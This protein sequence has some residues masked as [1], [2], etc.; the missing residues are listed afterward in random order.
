MNHLKFLDDTLI[1]EDY[2]ALQKRILPIL[3]SKRMGL[4]I[5]TIKTK[6]VPNNLKCIIYTDDKIIEY[7]KDYTCVR[8][9]III[10]NQ[11]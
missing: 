2:V 7:V 6:I 3:Q 4:T 8:H 9:F 1:T 11:T 10:E 5:N